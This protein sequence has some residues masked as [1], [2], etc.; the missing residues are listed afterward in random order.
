MKNN[1]TCSK[2]R[3][4]NKNVQVTKHPNV[5]MHIMCEKNCFA[6][7]NS[8]DYPTQLKFC[9]RFAELYCTY[10]NTILCK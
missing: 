9:R 8:I 1:N 2:I 4:R 5:G 3:H 6:F 10:T 7:T